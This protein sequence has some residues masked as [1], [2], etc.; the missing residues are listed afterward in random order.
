MIVKNR[1]NTR[2]ILFIFLLFLL[3]PHSME[4]EEKSIPYNAT[5]SQ[6]TLTF[7]EGMASLVDKNNRAIR[8]LT[9]GDV[10]GRGDR[11]RTGIKGRFSLKLPDGS[12]I[13][14]DEFTTIELVSLDVDEKTGQR[15]IKISLLSGNTWI[16]APKAYK[17]KEGVTV[18]TA[19]AVVRA[20]KSIYR[21]SVNSD[22]STLVKVYWG[23]IDVRN[24]E[25]KTRPKTANPL[26]MKNKI[27]DHV[28]KPMHQIHV[29]SDGTATNP[30]RFTL[31]ADESRWVQWNREQD[32]KI[33]N[34]P[35]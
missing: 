24:T 20:D 16:H 4:A 17:G 14:C 9:L 18:L 33:G 2:R 31:K 3:V 25:N 12:H 21:L 34:P 7:L 28:I 30:F 23:R 29:R 35:Q 26:S 15:N 27:W 10:C 8:S 19:F 1:F 6:A 11:I 5:E 22:K 13:R 32:E